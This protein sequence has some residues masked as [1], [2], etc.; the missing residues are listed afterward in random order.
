M[1]RTNKVIFLLVVILAT[2]WVMPPK[3]RAQTGNQA[4]LIIRHGENDVQTACVDFDEPQISGYD[5]LQRSG[6]DLQIGVQGLGSLICSID[7]TGCPANDCLCQCKGGG[8]CI[9]W[10]YWHR[11]AGTWQYSQGGASVYMVDPGVVEGW[12]WGPGAVN[13]AVPPPE[14]S[15]DAICQTAPTNTPTSSP[16]ATNTQPAIVVSLPSTATRAPSRAATATQLPNTATSTPAASPTAAAVVSPTATPH[17][18][19][20]APTATDTAVLLQETTL[21]PTAP[22]AEQ[23]PQ[24]A[25]ETALEITDTPEA[26]ASAAA[27]PAETAAP[28]LAAGVQRAKPDARDP[29]P[30]QIAQSSDLPTVEPTAPLAVIGAGVVPTA[31]AEIRESD[32]AGQESGGLTTA[33]YLPYLFFLIIVAGL[34]GLLL[35][36]SVRRKQRMQPLK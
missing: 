17:A 14:I 1:R 25:A 24:I 22:P 4:A 30:E 29:L 21:P 35:F 31:G 5:L 33:D 12:S 3:M 34:G 27:G 20:Q 15:F 10:S 32:R 19:Q 18:A 28:V 9:Y 2:L 23:Q 7:G 6:L 11:S 36:V 13:Q 26:V 16:T 8:D